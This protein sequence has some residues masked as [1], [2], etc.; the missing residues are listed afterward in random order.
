MDA[1]L[2]GQ[3]AVVGV[4][5]AAALDVTRH[6]RARFHAHEVA[7]LL[8]HIRA[9]REMLRRA[10]GFALLLA[11]L[12]FFGGHCALRHRDNREALVAL[13]AAFDNLGNLLDFVG[14][15]GNQDGIRAAR[16]AGIQRQP[17]RLV[18]HDF[19]HHA[20]PMRR[21]RS[22][23]AVDDLRRNVHRRVEAEREVRAVQVVVNC[24]GQT[25]DVQPF[26][27]KE[28]RRLVRA[29]AA[30]SD[31]AVKFQILVGLFHRGNLVHVILANLA[32]IAE[33]RARRAK[34]RAAKGQDAGELAA[35][36]LLIVAR[37]ESPIAVVD[38]DNLRVKQ[39]IRRAG[40]AADCRVQA[41]AV[42]A[43]GQN[44]DSSFHCQ[45]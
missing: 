34:N 13:R 20:A 25:D 45:T 37:D 42:A 32:H 3:H 24:L 15:F 12:R 10:L 22:V 38:A 30:E 43:A 9:G 11:H 27:G 21:R 5:A 1:E 7:E 16:H 39:F 4:R 33:G 44:T 28:V 35:L 14:D 19:H 17:A 8:R 23:N 41:G 26:L 6:N 29:I 2:R 36:H 18:A 31:K 40:H